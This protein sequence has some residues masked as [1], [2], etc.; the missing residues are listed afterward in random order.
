MNN[1]DNNQTF[2]VEEIHRIRIENEKR[3]K[4][5]GMTTMEILNDIHERA[6]E[7]WQ[8]LDRLQQEKEI[9]PVDNA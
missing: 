4:E 7:G 6:Q 1:Q 9:Q 3:Y 2:G 5:L 8:I